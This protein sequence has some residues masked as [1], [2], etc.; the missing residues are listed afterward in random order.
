MAACQIHVLAQIQRQQL[1]CRL[2]LETQRLLLLLDITLQ[3]HLGYI[4]GHLAQHMT[5]GQLLI[6]QPERCVLAH[7][8]HGD[9]GLVDFVQA[10]HGLAAQRRQ[11]SARRVASMM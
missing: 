10:G 9:Y 8:D 1:A 2:G 11:P 7:A 3:R 5:D 6:D 4:G